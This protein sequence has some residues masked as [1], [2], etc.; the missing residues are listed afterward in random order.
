MLVVFKMQH[1]FAAS[2]TI[3]LNKDMSMAFII[4]VCVLNSEKTYRVNK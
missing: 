2:V 4:H 1:M 3:Q